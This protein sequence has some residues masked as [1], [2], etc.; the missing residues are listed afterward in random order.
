MARR[1]MRMARGGRRGMMPKRRR[2][3]RINQGHVRRLPPW[4]ATVAATDDKPDYWPDP[5]EEE[6]G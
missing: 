4:D 3:K 6:E 1:R 2:R 5:V